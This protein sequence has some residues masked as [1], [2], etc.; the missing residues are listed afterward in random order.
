LDDYNNKKAITAHELWLVRQAW[1][2]REIVQKCSQIAAIGGRVVPVK[3][4]EPG[5]A[6]AIRRHVYDLRRR[7]GC[8]VGRMLDATRASP[9]SDSF[10]GASAAAV[11]DLASRATP[12]SSS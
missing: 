5:S 1:A 2:D 10:S 11:A 12:T 8:A 7:R 4:V 6:P 9:S 3:S